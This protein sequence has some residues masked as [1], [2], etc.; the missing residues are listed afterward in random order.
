MPYGLTGAPATF[1]A[2]MNHILKP[3]L[4]KYVVVFIDDILIYNKCYEEHLQH[5][6]MVFEILKEHQF[7][8]RL[9]KCVFAQQQLN[10]LGHVLSSARVAT[11]SSKIAI[12]KNWPIPSSVKKLRSFLGM[13]GY[14]RRFV[15]N[16]GAIAKP[17][18]ELLKKGQLFVWTVNH[19]ESFNA[20]KQALVTAPVLALPNFDKSFVVQTDASEKGIGVVLHQ[21]GHPIAFFSKALGPK[22]QGLSTY[23]K[24]SL[25]I[26]MDVD[27]LEVILAAC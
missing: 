21:E 25:A 10:Y 24:E 9:S 5:V 12:V 18:T 4:K 11:Y 3:L 6:K 20:L 22:N 15:Q 7:Q 8:V 19:E 27:H 26:L 13:A 17:L 23:E 14:Y 16:F 2:V 1:Q